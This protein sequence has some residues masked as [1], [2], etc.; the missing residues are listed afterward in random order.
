[1]PLINRQTQQEEKLEIADNTDSI[2][3]STQEYKMFLRALIM[4]RVKVRTREMVY[5]FLYPF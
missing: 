1:M 2:Q 3:K 5:E 4:H